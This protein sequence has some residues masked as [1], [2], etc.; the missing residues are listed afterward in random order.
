M[1]KQVASALLDIAIR[2]LR[3]RP[4]MHGRARF[5]RKTVSNRNLDSL[6]CSPKTRSI[7]DGTFTSA[8]HPVTRTFIMAPDGSR[9]DE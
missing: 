5:R 1:D 3:D 2:E 7:D 9:V 4:K 8:F 6:G